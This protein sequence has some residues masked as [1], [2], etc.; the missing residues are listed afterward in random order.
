MS[1][2]L[3]PTL[4]T[5]AV[6]NLLLMVSRSTAP[7]SAG[8]GHRTVCHAARR[9]IR[10]ASDQCVISEQTVSHGNRS[11]LVRKSHAYFIFIQ[12]S[13]LKNAEMLT[14][15]LL[16]HLPLDPTNRSTGN[17]PPQDETDRAHQKP[18]PLFVLLVSFY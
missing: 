7:S 14:N 16:S 15:R 10:S 2:N 13:S 17:V 3:T 11:L 6:V 18:Q 12:F 5:Y 8:G 9:T 4:M 1:T